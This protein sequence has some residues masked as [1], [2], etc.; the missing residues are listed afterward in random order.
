MIITLGDFKWKRPRQKTGEGGFLGGGT[1]V[2]TT[3]F[4]GL[5]SEV[6]GWCYQEEERRSGKVDVV[7]DS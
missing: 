3:L 7:G 4:L 6:G 1:L 5:G 2:I